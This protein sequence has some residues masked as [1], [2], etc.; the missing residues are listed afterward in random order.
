MNTEG[1]QPS[2]LFNRHANDPMSGSS[3]A[4]LVPLLGQQFWQNSAAISLDVGKRRL[5]VVL[6]MGYNLAFVHDGNVD[7]AGAAESF[8]QPLYMQN[9]VR[10]YAK[11]SSHVT[12][13]GAFIAPALGAN[14][15]SRC[16][17]H[18]GYHLV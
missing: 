13:S 14:C 1:F 7:Q 11:I 10:F 5:S 9:W 2:F 3:A 12:D 6:L 18:S 16:D 17:P 8:L 15:I 4:Q